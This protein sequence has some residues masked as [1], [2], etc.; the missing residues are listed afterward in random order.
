VPEAVLV[1]EHSGN[2][3]ISDYNWDSINNVHVQIVGYGDM[4]IRS[5]DMRWA[6]KTHDSRVWGNS[7]TK[8]MMESQTEFAING[9]SAYPGR[10]SPNSYPYFIRILLPV[11]TTCFLST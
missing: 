7:M 10:Y 4:L 2:D 1:P 6:G 5:I 9:D 11:S 3:I 8:R